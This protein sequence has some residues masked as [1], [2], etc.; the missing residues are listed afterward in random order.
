M[1]FIKIGSDDEGK[2]LCTLCNGKPSNPEFY[3]TDD[4][5]T[6][7]SVRDPIAIEFTEKN[8]KKMIEVF[9]NAKN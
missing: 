3:Y 6:C 9:K 8:L 5:G 1:G 4:L 2:L 7:K